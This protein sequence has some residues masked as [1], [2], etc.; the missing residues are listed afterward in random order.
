MKKFVKVVAVAL[1]VMTALTLFA[2]CGVSLDPDKTYDALL[3]NGYYCDMDTSALSL[4]TY[5][6]KLGVKA[7]DMSAVITANK[8][9]KSRETQKI[10]IF[11]FKDYESA[12]KAWENAQEL[13]E[14]AQGTR[15]DWV[16]E[17]YLNVIYF[18]TKQALK[19]AR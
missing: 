16:C 15:T 9:D 17:R 14:K 18:G 3:D 4:A 1:V 19:D 5:A 11:Y 10:T 2:A 8:T 6:G 12:Y 13:S 7:Y